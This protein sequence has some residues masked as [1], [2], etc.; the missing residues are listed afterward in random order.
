MIIGEIIDVHTE[1][2]LNQRGIEDEL[3]RYFTL[4]SQEV[5]IG[6]T[7]LQGAKHTLSGE[8]A[9]QAASSEKIK[10]Q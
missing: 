2:A 4:E 10:G 5:L 6:V 7:R 9:P 8:C 1:A 3:T